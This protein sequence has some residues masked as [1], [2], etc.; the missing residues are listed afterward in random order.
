MYNMSL[1][2]NRNQGFTLVELI[3]VIAIISVLSAAMIPAT[4]RYIEKSN[5]GVDEVYIDGVAD[6]LATIAATDVRISTCPATVTIDS[7]GKIQNSIATG[8]KASETEEIV[9]AFLAELYPASS[10]Q[11][12]SKYYTGIGADVSSGVTLYLD[13]NGCV[14]ISGTKNLNS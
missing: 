13:A 12:V 14:T 10:Q 7:A 9:D 3:V 8:P 5:I 6:G 11:F 2:K 4:F 1:K